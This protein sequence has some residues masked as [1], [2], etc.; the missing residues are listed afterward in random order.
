MENPIH[1]K[2]IQFAGNH[3]SDG[4]NAAMVEKRGKSGITGV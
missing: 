2:I 4:M 3:V 1:G